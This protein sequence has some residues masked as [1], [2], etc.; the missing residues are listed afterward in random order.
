MSSGDG[1]DGVRRRDPLETLVS[2]GQ[3]VVSRVVNPVMVRLLRSRL[4]GLVS[5][6]TLLLTV[7]GRRSGREYTFPVNYE[8]ED[9]RL[10]VTSTN[11]NWWKNLRDGGQTVEVVLRGERRTGHAEVHED[12]ES[13]AAYVHDRLRRDG[14]DADGDFMLRVDGDTVPEEAT[15][16]AHVDHLVLVTIDLD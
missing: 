3:T 6:G 7:T 1:A 15:L 14:V 8:Q 12:A 5:D 16:R 11:T 10:S 9:D 2:V 13:V 4:H